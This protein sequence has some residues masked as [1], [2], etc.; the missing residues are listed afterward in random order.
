MAHLTA[1]SSLPARGLVNP[2]NC[3]AEAEASFISVPAMNSKL[4]ASLQCPRNPEGNGDHSNEDSF[5]GQGYLIWALMS[6]EEFSKRKAQ[7]EGFR[8]TT[9]PYATD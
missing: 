2:G 7:G 6:A 8:H 4:G 3:W 9:V 5:G 1:A